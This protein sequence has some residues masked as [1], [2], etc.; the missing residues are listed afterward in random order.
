MLPREG[1]T[2]EDDFWQFVYWAFEIWGLKIHIISDKW[3]IFD[4]TKDFVQFWIFVIIGL[5]DFCGFL[6]LL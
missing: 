2:L 4:F 3:A 6:H 1:K 5:L